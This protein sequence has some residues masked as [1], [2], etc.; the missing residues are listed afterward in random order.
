MDG[1]FLEPGYSQ[2]MPEDW[3]ESDVAELVSDSIL[4]DVAEFWE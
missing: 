4:R 2:A 1:R 3:F